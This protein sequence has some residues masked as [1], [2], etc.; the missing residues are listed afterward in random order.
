MGILLVK[1]QPGAVIRPPADTDRA[2][3][4]WLIDEKARLERVWQR[5]FDEM[6]AGRAAFAERDRPIAADLL[7]RL[8]CPDC[9]GPVERLGAGVAC[10][11]CGVRFPGEYGVPILYPAHAPDQREVLRESVEALAGADAGR[12]RTV[13][14]LARRLRRNERMPG[15]FRRALWRFERAAGARP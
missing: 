13:S 7:A 11:A 8:A 9:R 10:T 3:V 4:R 12:R 14:R 6:D 15:P 5:L 2:L 1:A